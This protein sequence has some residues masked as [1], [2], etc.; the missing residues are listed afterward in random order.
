MGWSG[1][2]SSGVGT[3]AGSPYT[4]DVDAK[5]ILVTPASC[6]ASRSFAVARTLFAKTSRGYCSA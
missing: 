6:I 2:W 3:T 4:V 1:A 5:P